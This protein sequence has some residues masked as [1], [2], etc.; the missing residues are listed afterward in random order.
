LW[1]TTLRVKSL[2]ALGVQKC[3]HTVFFCIYIKSIVVAPLD[4]SIK[5]GLNGAL[6]N[7]KILIGKQNYN[8]LRKNKNNKFCNSGKRSFI[9]KR[10]KIGPRSEPRGTPELVSKVLLSSFCMRTKH[11]LNSKQ[12]F[13][14][15]NTGPL[16]P[17]FQVST[18]IYHN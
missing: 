8:V 1:Q 5:L 10:N 18:V 17:I 13:I 6:T 14:N 4:H 16:I 2:R 15:F 7:L 3:R 11:F 9:N 12:L